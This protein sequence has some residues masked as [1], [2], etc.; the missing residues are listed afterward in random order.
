MTHVVEIDLNNPYTK[1]IPGYK[2]MIPTEETTV[3]SVSTMA[4]TLRGSYGNV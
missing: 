3:S 1:V 2:G 4:S